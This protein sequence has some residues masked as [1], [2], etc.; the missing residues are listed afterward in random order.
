ML[1]DK[2]EKACAVKAEQLLTRNAPIGVVPPTAEEKVIAPDP[3]AKVRA[4]PAIVVPST[5]LPKEM[6]PLPADAS[7]ETGPVKV[8]AP[9]KVMLPFVVVT[10]LE[11][12]TGPDPICCVYDPATD[13]VP[14]DVI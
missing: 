3:A 7:K 13:A 14:V 2:A 8:T 4:W 9:T 11:V 12:I 6:F 5:V 10:E 1:T